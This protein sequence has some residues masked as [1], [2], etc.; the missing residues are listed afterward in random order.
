MIAVG[1]ILIILGVVFGIV[2]L[3]EYINTDEELR[4]S[5]AIFSGLILALGMVLIWTQPKDNDDDKEY[6]IECS[7]YKIINQ[8]Q[9]T[10]TGK[11]TVSYKK[12]VIKYKK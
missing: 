11:D 3:V 5:L 10:I 8:S 2:G 6:T 1:V 4:G 12:Y 9:M 7:D